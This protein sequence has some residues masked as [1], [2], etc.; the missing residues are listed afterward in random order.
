M[1]KATILISLVILRIICLAEKP[2]SLANH[3]LESIDPRQ[4][5]RI[6]EQVK[7]DQYPKLIYGN[8]INQ[9]KFI[10]DTKSC[11]YI[12]INTE[13]LANKTEFTGSIGLKAKINSSNIEVSA[14]SQVGEK[15][16][17]V[18]NESSI[19]TKDYA[20]SV[21]G[22]LIAAEEDDTTDRYHLRNG[23]Q[24][25]IEFSRKINPGLEERMFSRFDIAPSY[26]IKSDSGP[27]TSVKSIT[28][29]TFKNRMNEKLTY[30]DI[31]QLFFRGGIDN[32]IY[33][34]IQIKAP[35]SYGLLLTDS[36]PEYKKFRT[37]T[38][39]TPKLIVTYLE[40]E[41]AILNQ[42]NKNQES[43]VAANEFFYA[44][45]HISD[46]SI[47]LT[48][49]MVLKAPLFSNYLK[50]LSY[51]NLKESHAL[52][53]SF[54]YDP[55]LIKHITEAL[56]S[57]LAGLANL[58]KSFKVELTELNSG[59]IKK[60][61]I[62]DKREIYLSLFNNVALYY[63]Q[64][65]NAIQKLKS[66]TQ[67]IFNATTNNDTSKFKK[68]IDLNKDP[69]FK[70]DFI[71][72]I[73][74]SMGR[75][76]YKNLLTGEIDLEQA[77]AVEGGILRIRLAWTTV[78]NNDTTT[79]ELPIA[80]F[81]LKS[82]G[83]GM[84]VTDGFFAVNN[85]NPDLNNPDLSES[86]FLGAFGPSLLFTYVSDK[87]A[88][89][90]KKKLDPTFSKGLSPELNSD[91]MVQYRRALRLLEMIQ[92]SVG[93]NLAA[94]NFNKNKDFELGVGLIAGIFRDKIFIIG[95]YNVNIKSSPWYWGVGFSFVN[96]GS[97][98]TGTPAKI[99]ITVQ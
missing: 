71:N 27:L 17:T 34:L 35:E 43:E 40:E 99:P 25:A 82:T 6:Y 53:T 85:I 74:T 44:Y 62:K 3:S 52:T 36:I 5:I 31:Y 2:D 29:E 50:Y 81:Y 78:K 67:S 26:Y 60:D 8:E 41:I 83:W 95:G 80:E 32:Y 21:L 84:S 70:S 89:K 90:Y 51:I 75:L 19:S 96:L 47:Q 76:I 91:S 54:A 97:M 4:F 58:A 15:L 30:G 9:K 55:I 12:D 94:L 24:Y 16:S 10:V 63:K 65:D 14:Y 13:A 1:K 56:D 33:D 42:Y 57:S 88:I 22:L 93:V 38:N 64:F 61:N 46:I 92:P 49:F 23:Q 45:Q 86:R 98:F 66:R 69:N 72:K 20:S 68:Y 48:N 28:A 39:I 7:R 73:A 37:A 87:S 77:N 59:N 18:G 79:V 11:L